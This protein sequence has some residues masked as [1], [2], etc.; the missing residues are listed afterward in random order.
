M[1]QNAYMCILQN[2]MLH[3]QGGVSDLSTTRSV[4]PDSGLNAGAAV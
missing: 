3:G 1:N 2:A 4:T